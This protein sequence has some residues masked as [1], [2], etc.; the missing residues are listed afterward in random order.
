M[1]TSPRIH[2]YLATKSGRWARDLLRQDK[3]PSAVALIVFTCVFAGS[4]FGM[5]LRA[6]IPKHHL[7][8]DTENVIKLGMLRQPV[9]Q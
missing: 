3:I 9:S 4:L 7:Q 5:Y 6:L 2:H 8:E 1:R